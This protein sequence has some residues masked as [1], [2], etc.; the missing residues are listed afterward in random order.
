MALR[1]SPSGMRPVCPWCDRLH[2][3]GLMNEGVCHREAEQQSADRPPAN[4]GGSLRGPTIEEPTKALEAE[5]RHE[6]T[7]NDDDDTENVHDVGSATCYSGS[8]IS[9]IMG[10]EDIE[11]TLRNVNGMKSIRDP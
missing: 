10:F 5:Q 6:D 1:Y 8:G 9:I 7:D 2:D 3:R 4:K 11:F